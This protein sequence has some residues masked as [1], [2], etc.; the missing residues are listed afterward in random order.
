MIIS[1]IEAPMS[2][3]T[4]FQQFFTRNIKKQSRPILDDS[5]NSIVSPADSRVLIFGDVKDGKIECVKGITYTVDELI[6]GNNEKLQPLIKSKD[7]KYI[8]L[9]LSP[10][11]YHHYHSPINATFTD[12]IYIPGFLEPVKPSYIEKH[13]VAY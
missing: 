11:D 7:L 5:N 2:Q 3:F 4:T 13:K 6:T 8:V 10:G 9:Y 12:R 1:E